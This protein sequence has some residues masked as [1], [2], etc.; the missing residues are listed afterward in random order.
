[1]LIKKITPMLLAT[2]MLISTFSG[3]FI[4][5]QSAYSI[6][7]VNELS[8]VKKADW[9]YT[10]LKELVEKYDVV[11][12]YPD[13]TFK[14]NNTAS[15]YELAA[16]LNAAI[17]AMGKQF[18]RLGAEKADKED[19]AKVAKLQQELAAE[20]MALQARTDALEARATRIEAKNDEQD[21]RLAVMEKLRVYGDASLGGNADMLKGGENQDGISAI[22]RT[23]INVDYD[24]VEDKGGDVVGAGVLH[25]RL[26][27]AFGRNAPIGAVSGENSRNTFS[28]ISRI[29]AD[30]SLY[31]QGIGSNSFLGR[32]I[33]G[34]NLRATTYIES[35]YYSQI[36][37]AKL[38]KNDDYKTT[39]TTS[40][41]LI[42]WRDIFFQ[43]PYQGNENTQFQ[44]CA[45]IN[46]SAIFQD[47]VNPRFAVVMKQGLGENTDFSLKGDVSSINIS[48]VIDGIGFTFEGDLG[49]K[50][51]KLNNL[52]GNVLAGYSVSHMSNASTA[53]GFYIG[54]NQEI[55]KGAGIFGSYALNNTAEVAAIAS[56]LQN[57]SGRVYMYPSANLYGIKQSWVLG[58]EIPVK[59]LPDKLTYGKR[60]RD[61]MGI[62][63]AQLAP[64]SKLANVPSAVSS[65]KLMEM[66]YRAQLTE[67]F[68]II[69]SMQLIFNRA[70]EKSNTSDVILGL[71]S[72]F[73]F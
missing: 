53:N 41:G 43:S 45:L 65:E 57:S 32:T 61:A 11:E 9:A 21:N 24:V 30:A 20:L 40:A 54:A 68:A 3:C 36:L 14:G 70:G 67:G 6:T 22:G 50:I 42:P 7:R 12:G 31:N 38:S 26:V 58:S 59:A 2:S 73:A 28:G 49:Y 13:K 51:A 33:G 66:Y 10:V 52:S 29:A 5:T 44:N 46:N 63:Y 34:S 37:K 35:A 23:R 18:A 47:N 27:A 71:R 8:D 15:R 1:M 55:Y 60:Q 25:S 19:L 69:P 64:N 4:N 72:S 17:K 56:S 62:A 16:A 39:F 48:D